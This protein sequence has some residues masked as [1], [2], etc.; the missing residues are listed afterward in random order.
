MTRRELRESTFKMLFR[1]EFHETGE[2]QE[3]M[4]LFGEEIAGFKEEEFNYLKQ[5]CNNIIAHVNEIDEAINAVSEGWKTSRMG[6]VDL[7]LIRL[8]VYE[9]RYEEDIP[10]K[11]SVNEAV[12]LAKKYGTDDSPS[13]VNG[14][15]AKFA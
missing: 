12:E 6:K 2:L 1:I 4:T 3:Q 8:A 10:F 14:I 9:I 5:K 11:V 7:T 15:L 13:F